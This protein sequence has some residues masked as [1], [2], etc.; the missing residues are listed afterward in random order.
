M[1]LWK[2][3]NNNSS[4]Q[5]VLILRRR[6]LYSLCKIYIIYTLWGGNN[7]WNPKKMWTIGESPYPTVTIFVHLAG[8]L[9]WFEEMAKHAKDWW[10]KRVI[11]WCVQEPFIVFSFSSQLLSCCFG[12][13]WDRDSSRSIW[14]SPIRDWRE[15]IP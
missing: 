13:Q 11:E 7:H 14:T 1:L 9:I 15:K 12:D 2:N 8:H 4:F 3:N 6:Q 5:M 10:G